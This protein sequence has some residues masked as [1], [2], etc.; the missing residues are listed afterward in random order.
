MEVDASHGGL[1][2]VLSQ[3][4]NG[5][6][7]P[8]AYASSGLRPTARN[9]ANY[10]SRK[11][12]FLAL[13]WAMSEKFRDYLLGHKCIVYTDN[14]PLSHF[15]VTSSA[16][17]GA[18]EQRWVA[19]LAAFDFEVKYRSGR[20][21]K[22]VDALSR[23]HPPGPHHD[24]WH[25]AAPASQATI[26]ALPHH[27]P[28]D[29]RA[30]QHADPFLQEVLVFWGQKQRPNTWDRRHISPPALAIVRQ[31]SRLVEQDGGPDGAEAVFQ[32]L[33]P[34]VLKP[35]VMAQVHQ[36]HGH[37][38]VERTLELLRVTNTQSIQYTKK[39]S[40]VLL[41]SVLRK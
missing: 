40:L 27:A 24:S 21:N 33:L 6:V 19:Q 11:L 17:F 38:G 7:R 5:K 3:E 4:Q 16:R 2:A 25:L 36:G 8:I 1:G 34:T 32:V 37:R 31:W 13:K 39:S 12:E 29:L 18:T 41:Q 23:R 9:M 30:L 14:N 35:E 15:F 20:S 26:V 10:S 22:N 28:S